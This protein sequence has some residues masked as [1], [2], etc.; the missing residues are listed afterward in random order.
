M[1][2]VRI[3]P[4]QNRILWILEEAG[5]ETNIT[6][7]A[8]LRSEKAYPD[9]DLFE[10]ALQG[11]DRLGYIRRENESLVMTELGYAALSR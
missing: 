6:V 11:L 3:S 1:K 8:T 9:D 10:Q 4:L 2:K 5:E 7:V